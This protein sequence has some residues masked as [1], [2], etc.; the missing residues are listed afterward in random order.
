LARR[1]IKIKTRAVPEGGRSKKKPR[2]DGTGKMVASRRDTTR[3]RRT[4]RCHRRRRRCTRDFSAWSTES[5]GETNR[6]EEAGRKWRSVE[7]CPEVDG[8]PATAGLGRGTSSFGT[9]SARRES[10]RSCRARGSVSSSSPIF[11][12]RVLAESVDVPDDLFPRRGDVNLLRGRNS[13]R[14]C[15]A[16]NR[17]RRFAKLSFRE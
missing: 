11:F 10:P 1:E 6:I 4:L 12:S 7:S 2:N 17:C 5:R 3:R 15:R 14:K 13:D 16:L 8:C 9:S